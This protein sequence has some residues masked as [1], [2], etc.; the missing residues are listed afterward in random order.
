MVDFLCE[1]CNYKTFRKN[2]FNKHLKTLKHKN[3]EEK[4]GMKEQ[5]S[6]KKDHKKTNLGPFSATKETILG[7]QKDHFCDLCEKVFKNKTHL[8]RHQ[9]HYCKILMFYSNQGNL[10]WHH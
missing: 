8:Y 2:D 6:S 7:P 3:N 9:K 10:S 5:K 1:I 4:K